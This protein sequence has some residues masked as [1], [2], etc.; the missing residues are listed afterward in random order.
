MCFHARTKVRLKIR[1]VIEFPTPSSV[2]DVRRFV[3]MAS[4]YRPFIKR[5]ADIAAPLN[6]LTRQ[7]TAFHWDNKCENAFCYLKELLTSP[8]ILAYPNFQ[9]EFI[10]ETDL[11]NCPAQRKTTLQLKRSV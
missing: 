1:D 8:P 10:V 3:G 2:P 7:K 4:Y 9:S 11:G 5:F 6:D